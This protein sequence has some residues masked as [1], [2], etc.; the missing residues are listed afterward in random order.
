MCTLIGAATAIGYYEQQQSVITQNIKNVADITT[1]NPSLPN[2]EEG[3]SATYTKTTVTDL[4]D[5][6]DVTTYKSNVILAFSSSDISA[7]TT[8]YSQYEIVIKYA[9]VPVGSTSTVGDVAATITM[10]SPN[11]SSVTLD[12]AGNWQFDYEIS[13]TALPGISADTSSTATVTVTASPT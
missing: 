8:K 13:V 10:A 6:A 2:L 3:Q 7:L 11:P 9:V 1:K 4:G 12:L 5:A